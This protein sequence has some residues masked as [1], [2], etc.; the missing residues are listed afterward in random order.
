MKPF[1]RHKLQLYTWELANLITLERKGASFP[2]ITCMEDGEK[3][4]KSER[5]SMEQT[6]GTCDR[7]K[8]TK[9]RTKLQIEKCV[10]DISTRNRGL[11]SMKKKYQSDV[12]I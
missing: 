8:Q 12:I 1:S 5:R 6:K 10:N 9:L 3:G 2:S 7:T 4:Q 11:I